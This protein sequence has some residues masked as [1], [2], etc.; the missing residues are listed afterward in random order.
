MKK[1]WISLI[2]LSVL[3]VAVT[4]S[5]TLKI[6]TK[7]SKETGKVQEINNNWTS[8]NPEDIQSVTNL[9]ANGASTMTVTI[10]TYKT[11]GNTGDPSKH[12]DG[13]TVTCNGTKS[14]ITAGS[15][16]FCNTNQASVTWSSTGNVGAQGVVNIK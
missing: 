12:L 6:T 10:V 13:I 5:A 14:T 7:A 16:A 9:S 1:L 3:G 8:S 4:A 15:S 11:A 2:A